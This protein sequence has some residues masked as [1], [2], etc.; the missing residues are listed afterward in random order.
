MV[1]EWI[2]AGER[3]LVNAIFMAGTQ[4]GPAF[5][6]L[7]VAWLVSLVGWRLGFALVGSIGF[8]WLAAWLRWFDRPEKVRWLDEAE[9]D[10]I[11]RERDAP[12]A[13]F[14]GGGG[15]AVLALLRN[16]SMWG[17]ALSE[18]CAVYTQY[19]FLTWLPGY[20]QTTRHL[21]ILKTGAY[22]AVPYAC[23]MLLGIGLGRVSDRLLAR[24]GVR[25]GRR[26][27]MVVVMLL[28]SS[29]ILFA[30]LVDNIWIL[31]TLFTLSL[32]GMA[33]AISNNFALV[34]DLLREPSHS[35]AAMGIL[36]MGGNAFG[37]L[38]PILTG[39]VIQATGSFDAAFGI[40]GALLVL[41]AVISLTLTRD[42][43]VV[44]RPN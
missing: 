3:G 13:A 29:V 6:A 33:S 2:P 40:A 4:A 19:L 26:R 22:T 37:I 27:N 30:P 15:F 35:G 12:P 39:Y 10:H 25:G 14:S 34:N 23:A 24:E 18:G 16:R 7:V 11:L 9:R 32:T 28:S 8:L 41:G 1:R 42:A 21:S 5:G 44:T 36:I 17:L 43:I 38:A 20:L 31:L